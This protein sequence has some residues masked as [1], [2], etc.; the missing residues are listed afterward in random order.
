M[1]KFR[2]YDQHQI[3]LFPPSMHDWIPDDHPAKFIDEVV[4]TLDL[5]AIYESY[6][7]SKGYPPYSPVMM[8]KFNL[9]VPAPVLS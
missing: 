5:S 4:G 6:T 9:T 7:E 1:K 3:M 2:E 8:V